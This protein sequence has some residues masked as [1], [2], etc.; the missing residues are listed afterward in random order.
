MKQIVIL[1]GKGGTG[2]TSFAASFVHLAARDHEIVIADADVDASNLDLVLSPTVL[3]THDFSSG[4]VA[5]ILPEECISCDVCVQVCRFDAIEV[6]DGVYTVDPIAC[7]GCAA[8]FYQCP[9]EAIVLDTPVVG[10]WFKSDTRFGPMIH[11]HL[12][13]G[14][15]NSGKLVTLVKQQARLIALDESRDYVIVDGPP[16]I[17]CPV[18]SSMTGVDQVLIVTEPTPSGQ[19][20]LARVVELAGHFKVKVQ[21]CINQYDINLECAEDIGDWCRVLGINVVGRI[22]FYPAIPRIQTRGKA[23]VEEEGEEG[24]SIRE[25]WNRVLEGE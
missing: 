13:A 23:P 9:V 4:V 14:Q 25:L 7:D 20:D 8:C 22:P 15:E 16:G 18:I 11:A 17:G 24:E 10:R 1:S 19:H 3:E 6:I 12:F 21:V 5:R 2:K